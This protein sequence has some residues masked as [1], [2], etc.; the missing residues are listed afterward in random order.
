MLDKIKLGTTVQV[1]VATRPTNA[2]A[3]KTIKRILAK[4]PEIA[5]EQRRIEKVRKSQY[6]PGRRGGRLYGG[7]QVKIHPVKGVVGESGTVVATVDVITDLKS[8]SRFVEV[9]AA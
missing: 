1:K 2:A 8:V 4:S 5:A 7:R 6:N 9:T 3:T